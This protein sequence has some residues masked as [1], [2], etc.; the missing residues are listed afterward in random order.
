ML[1]I[2]LVDANGKLGF[3]PDYFGPLRPLGSSPQSRAERN[4]ER[5]LLGLNLGLN[6]TGSAGVNVNAA[7]TGAN[8][9]GAIGG[10]GVLNTLCLL[11]SLPTC[12][13]RPKGTF[14]SVPIIGNVFQGTYLSRRSVVSLRDGSSSSS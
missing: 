11:G 4:E 10:G 1:F 7:A 5:Q 3:T 6:V 8:L 12:P 13:N 2:D 14:Q 9:N